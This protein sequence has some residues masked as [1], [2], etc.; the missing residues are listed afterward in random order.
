MNKGDIRPPH[1]SPPEPHYKPCMIYP[2]V[3]LAC[4]TRPYLAA[5]LQPT[6]TRADRGRPDWLALPTKGKQKERLPL[7]YLPKLHECD[8]SSLGLLL[9][10]V[11]GNQSRKGKTTQ[12]DYMR[13]FQI[14]QPR[15]GRN[16][17]HSKAPKA[18]HSTACI[19]QQAVNLK[20]F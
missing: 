15:G 6:V 20:P 13:A 17:S 3:T 18:S 19:F 9:F 2:S 1:H 5:F 8:L 14:G 4:K 7:V 16:E 11:R 10:E 12:D